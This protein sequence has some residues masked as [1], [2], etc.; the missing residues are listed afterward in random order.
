MFPLWAC[1]P[2]SQSNSGHF[3]LSYSFVFHP[4]FHNFLLSISFSFALLTISVVYVFLFSVP[5]NK[6]R[7]KTENNLPF[8]KVNYKQ[9]L[10][11]HTLTLTHARTHARI[12]TQTHKYYTNKRIQTQTHKYYT[13]KT[14]TNTDTHKPTDTEMTHKH[15]THTHTH[16]HTHRH[17]QTQK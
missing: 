8:S 1:L 9:P 13:N 6:S 16:T 5:V 2:V 11:T 3:L 10:N 12:Q 4:F 7:P 14:H 15:G 17:T